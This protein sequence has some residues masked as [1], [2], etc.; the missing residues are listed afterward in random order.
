MSRCEWKPPSRAACSKAVLTS[1][2]SVP[3]P[4]R[5]WCASENSGSMPD[6]AP[7][8]IAIVPVG[9]MQVRVALRYRGP[10]A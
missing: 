6:E 9:A 1:A 8:M 5:R 3:S 2:S 7:A 4:I 10:P